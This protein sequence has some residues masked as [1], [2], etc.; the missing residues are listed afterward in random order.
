MNP[1]RIALI[2][3]YEPDERLIGLAKTM[4]D[5]GFLV[6]IV[7]DGSGAAY[8]RIFEAAGQAATVL[9]HERNRGKGTAV[10]TGLA[11]IS[12]NL[13][14]PYTVVTMDADGQHDPDDLPLFTAAIGERRDALFVGVRDFE[15]AANVPGSS[16][17]G[18]SFS[19]SSAAA[20]TSRS[21]RW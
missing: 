7:D 9:T 17:F 4:T 6:L 8:Q 12:E 16:R 19:N 14:A 15:H 3:A 2:P 5:R 18:R 20:T 13:S 1:N 21:K 11:W 10:K